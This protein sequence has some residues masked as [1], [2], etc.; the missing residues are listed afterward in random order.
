MIL[1]QICMK[2]LFS[3]YVFTMWCICL[4]D[5]VKKCVSYFFQYIMTEIQEIPN[6]NLTC[7][8]QDAIIK[9]RELVDCNC[10]QRVVSSN[11]RSSEREEK[12]N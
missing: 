7:N 5:H 10:L 8:R 9:R 1:F 11:K 4:K 3:N 12:T 6:C 2:K